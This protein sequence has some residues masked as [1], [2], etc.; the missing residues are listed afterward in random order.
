MRR[1]ALMVACVVAATGVGVAI[2]AGGSPVRP[3]PGPDAKGLV[4]TTTQ[5]GKVVLATTPR[6]MWDFYGKVASS[7]NES[8]SYRALCTALE[9]PPTPGPK[10]AF[11]GQVR[12]STVIADRLTCTI[13]VLFEND[14]ASLVMQGVV[15]KPAGSELFAAPS[16]RL[17]ALTGGTGA[18]TYQGAIGVA[19]LNEPRKITIKRW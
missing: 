9:P 16:D 3:P 1:A 7:N 11:T 12:A 8:G 6:V 10:P 2:A 13:V 17:L 14:N 15:T 5:E 19:Q 18:M 4:L